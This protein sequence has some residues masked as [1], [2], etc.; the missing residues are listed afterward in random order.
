MLNRNVDNTVFEMLSARN[1]SVL[2]EFV[3]AH[4]LLSVLISCLQTLNFKDAKCR[5]V[6]I[7]WYGQ[8]QQQALQA[9]YMQAAAERLSK[10]M[11]RKGLDVMFLKGMCLA[12]YYP[13]ADMRPSADIDYY[14]Y[15]RQEEGLASLEESG[16]QN[17]DVEDYH[18][19]AMMN[20]VRLELHQSFIID[21]DRLNTNVIVES[22]LRELAETE[23]KSTAVIGCMKA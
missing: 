19:H 3:S 11:Q 2:C 7:Q 21:V 14:L 17:E 13:L 4:G 1:L 12:Q 15:G 5:K 16:F 9:Q 18:A 6:I 22:A 8:A 10:L 20:G 23:G